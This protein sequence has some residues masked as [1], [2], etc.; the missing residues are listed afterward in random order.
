M[1]VTLRRVLADKRSWLSPLAVV[2]LLNV[3]AYA[4]AVYPLSVKVRSVQARERAAATELGAAQRD[5]ADAQA[6]HTARDRANAALGAFYTDVL[7]HDLAGAFRMTY[8][9]V[10]R[11]AQKFDLRERRRN[12]EPEEP[13][14]DSTLGRLRISMT[15]AGEWEDMRQFIYEL[16]TAPEFVVIDDISLSEG[17]EPGAALVL[18][19]AFSTYY[20][21]TAD[22]T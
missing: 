5:N 16:E 1:N 14:Q 6:A 10:S 2:F 7:P 18:T 13:E 3:A 8:L 21:A 20:R 11:L 12:H 4:L 17:S 9:R 19:L 22:G 15:L